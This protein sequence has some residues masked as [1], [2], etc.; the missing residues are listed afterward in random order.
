MYI[1]VNSYK[2][3]C[4][5]IYIFIYICI[6]KYIHIYICTY[7]YIYLCF[8]I[9]IHVYIYIYAIFMCVSGVD[10]VSSFMIYAWLKH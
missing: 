2:H 4:T 3:T 8:N 6:H 10:P 1:Y 7:M 9:Y 5:H